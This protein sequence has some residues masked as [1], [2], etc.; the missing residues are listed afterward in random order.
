MPLSSSSPE[1]YAAH[2]L[3]NHATATAFEGVVWHH[4]DGRMATL[5]RRDFA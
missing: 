3:V 2:G 5:K 4:S 1:G